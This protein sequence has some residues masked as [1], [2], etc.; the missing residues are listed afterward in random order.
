[1][2]LFIIDQDI[3]AGKERNMPAALACAI[4]QAKDVFDALLHHPDLRVQS[5]AER[6][7]RDLLN[8]WWGITSDEEA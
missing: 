2:T 8:A 3:E 5:L 1:V 7:R 4:R 6:A